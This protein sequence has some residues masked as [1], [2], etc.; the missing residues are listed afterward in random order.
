MSGHESTPE[1]VVH[2]QVEAYNQGDIDAFVECYSEQATVVDLDQDE[3]LG[4]GKTA[5]RKHFGELFD[6]FPDLRCEVR[7]QFRV[8]EYVVLSERV[9]GSGESRNAL[10]VYRVEDGLIQG[11][12]LGES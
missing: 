9:T 8:G 11:L 2:Q 7:E 6:N 3:T 12:W 5:I 4:R 1:R 10:A